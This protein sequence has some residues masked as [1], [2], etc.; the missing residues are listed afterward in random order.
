MT[1][2]PTEAEIEARACE[3]GEYWVEQDCEVATVVVVGRFIAERYEPRTHGQRCDG[4]GILKWASEFIGSSETRARCPGC[5]RCEPPEPEPHGEVSQCDLCSKGLC[6]GFGCGC[7]C[8]ADAP[9]ANA[10]GRQSAAPVPQVC[11]HGARRRVF[12]C[13]DCGEIDPQT[14][15]SSSEWEAYSLGRYDERAT[16]VPQVL[17]VELHSETLNALVG[18][19]LLV[20]KLPADR[21][22]L[23]AIS[24]A[25]YYLASLAELNKEKP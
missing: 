6:C 1:Y 24:A 2:K 25:N 14:N 23:S 18:L 21:D 15:S 9:T 5:P 22:V 4:S 10:V 16:P 19:L 3:F 13:I 12:R 7:P 8:H 20:A 17:T 11:A